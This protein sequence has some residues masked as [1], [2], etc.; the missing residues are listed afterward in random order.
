MKYWPDKAD[1]FTIWCNKSYKGKDFY[2]DLNIKC[3]VIGFPTLDE[4][5]ESI[6]NSRFSKVI[7]KFLNAII[8]LGK[9]VVFGAAVV[10]FVRKLKEERFDVIFSD[11]GGY[12]AAKLCLAILIAS[13]I[14]G[15]GKRFLIIHSYPTPIKSFF[16]VLDRFLDKIVSWSASEIITVSNAC[17]AQYESLRFQ[18]RILK[19]IYNG[20]SPK[21]VDSMPLKDKRKVLGVDDRSEIIGLIGDY[22]V[23][24]GHESLVK[25]FA[26]IA[27]GYPQV[28]MVFIGSDAYD[29]AKDLKRLIKDLQL[30]GRI[31]FTGYLKNAQEYIE[32]FKVLV[33]PSIAYEGFG[34]VLLEAMLYKKPV[35][36]AYMGG[37][38]KS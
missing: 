2:K 29:Y 12:P 23:L 20:I 1:E 33:L 22:E 38:R 13:K 28:K 15:T 17:A 8:S 14:A 19:V 32:C 34:I 10:F 31:I 25:A 30:E 26:L 18:G 27:D 3:Q 37:Y 6:E 24:K 7:K 5:H 35:V 16:Q 4:I 9:Y 11:N 36:G 21:R